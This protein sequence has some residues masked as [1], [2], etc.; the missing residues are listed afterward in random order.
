MVS[1]KTPLQEGQKAREGE[2]KVRAV[3]DCA[4]IYSL[5]FLA[6]NPID[7][8][9]P[10]A[11]LVLAFEHSISSAARSLPNGK[12]TLPSLKICPSPVA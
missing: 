8:P 6:H 9:P 3:R 1:K 10:C 5:H 12:M 7:I 2:R 4:G 11:A